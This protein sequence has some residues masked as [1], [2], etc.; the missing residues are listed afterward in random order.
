MRTEGSTEKILTEPENTRMRIKLE[1]EMEKEEALKQ[2]IQTKK[3]TD[4]VVAG[5]KDRAI[6]FG[7]RIKVPTEEIKTEASDTA[8]KEEASAIKAR[9]LDEDKSLQAIRG[10][11][12]PTSP[13]AA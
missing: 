10:R 11:M 5:L 4:Q 1:K 3:S 13:P 6:L 12:F 7:D 2:E 9:V 8:T